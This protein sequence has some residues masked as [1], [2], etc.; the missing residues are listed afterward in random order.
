MRSRATRLAL[1]A[2]ALFVFGAA[3]WFLFDSQQKISGRLGTFR[4][5]DQRL[6]E[7]TSELSGMR[8]AQQ[9]YVA[10]GQGAAFWIPEV[11]TLRKNAAASVAALREIASLPG[12]DATLADAAASL[13]AFGE[14][15]ARARE[16]L[17]GGESLMAADVVFTEGG[18]TATAAAHALEAARLSEQL[19]FDAF[20]AAQRR[21]QGYALAGAGVLG[22]F[23]I[24]L[25]APVAVPVQPADAQTP[26]E[27]G[28]LVLRDEA[29]PAP[30][31]AEPLPRETLPALKEA[32]VLCTDFARVNDVEELSRLLGRVSEVM[33]TRGL[34]VWLG[35]VGGADLK[36]V[37]AHGY[38]DQALAQMPAVPRSADNAAAAAFRTGKFQI[39]LARPGTASGAV[40]A[41]LLSP[42]GCIGALTAEM[43]GGG[44]TSDSVQALAEIFA[45]Q[46][47]GVLA[48]SVPAAE[49]REPSA[50]RTAAG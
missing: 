40:V 15:D 49:D 28:G 17:R 4:A 44:E 38:S 36:P 19:G 9:A 46:L 50:S 22:A 34:I 35:G 23:A 12:T 29:V 30:Q 33:D 42:T 14:V 20:E 8:A 31:P 18:E 47:A 37:L 26:A 5:F 13:D 3:T 2:V 16:Y 11:A 48:S 43:N 32:A 25:L 21:L 6:R 1:S 7:V 10:A 24:L 39:V 27:A 41:P 45:A